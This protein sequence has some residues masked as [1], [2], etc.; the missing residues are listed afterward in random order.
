MNELLK[1]ALSLGVGI[2]VASKEKLESIV[3]ELV[4]KGEIAP[5]QSK[6]L[7]SRLIEMGEEEKADIKR[8]LRENMQKM[9]IELQVPTKQDIERLEQR[10][11]KL[12][13]TIS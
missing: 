9:L 10:V 8:I 7:L 6:E 3:D 12:E 2:T 4:K 11:D 13:S 1:K 5:A